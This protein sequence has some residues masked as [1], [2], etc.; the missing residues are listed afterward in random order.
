MYAEKALLLDPTLAEGVG[1]IADVKYNYDWD[2]KGAE[3]YFKRSLELDPNLS[4]VRL[5]YGWFLAGQGRFDDGIAQMRQARELDPL[6]VVMTQQVG[7]VYVFAGQYDSALAY[8]QRAAEIDST[9]P[10]IAA[11]RSLVYL[12]KGMYPEAIEEAR[13][14][15]SLG[16]VPRGLTDLAIAYALS[17]QTDKARET[18]AR[19]L[20]WM[21]GHY[22]SFVYVARV[23]C[24]LGDRERVFEYLEKA[25]EEHDDNLIQPAMMP[26]WCDF[27][28][29]DPRYKELMKKVG[30]EQ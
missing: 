13:K 17:G 9:F 23:Y 1:L 12:R 4:D 15:I 10:L 30:V 6:S 16:N 28:K 7:Q 3:E 20:E 5:N 8:A 19:L 27:I 18:L 2:F 29:S 21:N 11:T 24:A 26:P 22:V 25:H 14:L